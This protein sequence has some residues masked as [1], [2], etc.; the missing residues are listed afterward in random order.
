MGRT[1]KH[2][3]ISPSA[4]KRWLELAGKVSHFCGGPG[5]SSPASAGS[6][7]FVQSAQ[8]LNLLIRWYR[9]VSQ[10]MYSTAIALITLNNTCLRV[11][12]RARSSAGALETLYRHIHHGMRRDRD[13]RCELC[14]ITGKTRRVLVIKRDTVSDKSSAGVISDPLASCSDAIGL[15]GSI[16]FKYTHL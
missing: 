8:R 6:G 11:R 14:A 16:A 4:S 3:C 15:D 9:S 10:N 7:G 13:L 1:P 12:P 5:A 2:Y